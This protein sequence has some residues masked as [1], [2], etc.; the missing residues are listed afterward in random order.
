MHHLEVN[1]YFVHCRGRASILP[2]RQSGPQE[3][4]QLQSQLWLR[5]W[6]CVRGDSSCVAS[7]VVFYFQIRKM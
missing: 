4:Y 5:A 2:N 6:S 1:N 3:A 7:N